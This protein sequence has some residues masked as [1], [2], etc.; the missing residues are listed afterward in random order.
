M[1]NPNFP[2]FDLTR[3]YQEIKGEVLERVN[4]IF[5]KQT[6]IL[7][8]EVTDFE[9]EIASYIGVKFALTCGSGTDA[10]VLAL[11]AMGVGA[12]DEVITSPFSFF[13]SASSIL[14]AGA[15]PVFADIDL[16]S[17][18]LD[19]SQIESKI[20]SKT[21][22]IMPVHLFGQTAE[23]EPLMALSRKTGIPI[24][25]DFAQSIGAKYHNLQSGGMGLMGAT[26]FYPTKNL[27]GAGEGGLVT[28]NDSQ[29]ADKV[30][31]LRA[32]GM[33]V[34]YT[35][36]ILGWNS[37]MDA[38]QVAVCRVKLRHLD[39]LVSRRQALA[40][41]YQEAL[42]PLEKKNKIR[43]P[44]TLGGR[45]HV[46][47]QFTVL[48]ENRDQVRAALEQKGIPTDIFYPKTIPAQPVFKA[49]GGYNEN[50]FPISQFAA[51]R[52][53]ALPIFPELRDQEQLSVIK[54]LEEILA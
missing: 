22:A 41:Q 15:K 31:L 18:N 29:L 53:L 32:H 14:L 28:T 1:A 8:Q 23:M 37:R 38:L 11:K 24:V 50:E 49:M 46:W 48:V 42:G 5:E 25:E 20:T 9:Q 17:F 21:K 2:F 45:F 47:N 26:S 44:K 34:R 39:R 30:K 4:Q 54:A 7:G 12:G 36:D 13:A 35:H 33:K 6:F 51:S 16:E 27:G 40:R 10:L 52:A 19:P 43:L 3:Q